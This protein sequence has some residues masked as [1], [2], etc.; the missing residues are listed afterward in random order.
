MLRALRADKACC[1]LPGR[2]DIDVDLEGRFNFLN[3][4]SSPCLSQ[5]PL[6]ST[7]CS[8]P[9]TA[10]GTTSLAHHPLGSGGDGTATP[11]RPCM[12][13]GDPRHVFSA[14]AAPLAGGGSP[15]TRMG[16]EETLLGGY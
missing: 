5:G 16:S 11:N 3:L 7:F 15:Q 2:G 13:S 12:P 6:L 14:P 10:L 4:V 1:G 9:R 8:A